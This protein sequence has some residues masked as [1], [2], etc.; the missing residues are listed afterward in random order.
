MRKYWRAQQVNSASYCYDEVNIGLIEVVLMSAITTAKSSGHGTLVPAEW[1]G[2]FGIYKYSKQA[3][4]K[5]LGPI[6]LAFLLMTFAS[7]LIDSIFS[8]KGG[9]AL[10]RQ[11]LNLAAGSYFGIIVTLLVLAGARGKRL[12]LGDTFSRVGKYLLNM[13]VLSILVSFIAIVS[14]LLLVIPFFIV[15]PRLTLASYFLVDKDL[16]AVDALKASWNATE[17]NVGKVWGIIGASL[18]MALFIIILVG[19]YF[20]LMYS[21]AFAILYLFLVRHKSHHKVT[22]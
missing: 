7:I 10:I 8:G 20:L 9:A 14:F 12:E 13:I 17:G 4:M 5:N 21:A 6:I 19:I 2:A 16:E 11:L 18:A 22:K 15:M 3:V 1:P